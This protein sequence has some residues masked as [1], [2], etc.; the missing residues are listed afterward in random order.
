VRDS[1]RYY[2]FYHSQYLQGLKIFMPSKA[3]EQSDPLG[4]S[5]DLLCTSVDSSSVLRDMMKLVKAA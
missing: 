4:E 1:R 2:F 3:N 5:T